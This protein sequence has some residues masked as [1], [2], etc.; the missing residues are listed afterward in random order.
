VWLAAPKIIF[1]RAARA[2]PS[3]SIPI[4]NVKV[5]AYKKITNIKRRFKHCAGISRFSTQSTPI[6]QAYDGISK[7]LKSMTNLTM[8]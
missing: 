6:L 2:P 5:K 7:Q 4:L 3:Q 1:A 8:R